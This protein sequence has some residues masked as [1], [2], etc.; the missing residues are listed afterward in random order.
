MEH[1]GWQP[2][3]DG[4]EDEDEDIHGAPL[5][6]HILS[7]SLVLGA[8]F[9]VSGAED[10]QGLRPSPALIHGQEPLEQA[11]TVRAPKSPQLSPQCSS[12]L[13]GGGLGGGFTCKGWASRAKTMR[14]QMKSECS[15]SSAALPCPPGRD[16]GMGTHQG[17]PGTL[18]THLLALA[19]LSL[20]TATLWAGRT[21]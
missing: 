20:G 3:R 13:S 9:S 15:L 5:E 21:A 8:G 4:D 11:A 14:M 19:P 10:A 12:H 1:A 7:H 18:S 17:W 2:S 16:S 6:Q